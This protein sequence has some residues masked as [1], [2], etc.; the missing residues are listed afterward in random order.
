[1]KV[2]KT[3]FLSAENI[4]N[5]WLK[6]TLKETLL[7]F[8]WLKWL[9][10]KVCIFVCWNIIFAIHS[11][12][13]YCFQIILEMLIEKGYEKVRGLGSPVQKRGHLCRN[14][15]V[16]WGVCN[17][18]PCPY[19]YRFDF[20]FLHTQ[21]NWKDISK[22][23]GDDCLNFSTHYYRA[24]IVRYFGDDGFNFSAHY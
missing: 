22:L 7:S 2:K 23:F 12:Y 24:D 10:S 1:M 11:H 20:S 19:Q 17:P 8:S 3:G 6:V 16:I 21:R 5:L 4:R 9:Y 14:G 13:L 18:Y 15:F